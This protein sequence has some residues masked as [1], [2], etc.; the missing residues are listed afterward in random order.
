VELADNMN[1]AVIMT[2]H[3]PSE[4]VFDMLQDLYLLEGGR[5]AYN[6]PLSATK[7]YFA[8]LGYE[9]SSFRSPYPENISN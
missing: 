4:M 7:R 5:L 1:V 9:V 8:S 3:Q 6:G 2:I